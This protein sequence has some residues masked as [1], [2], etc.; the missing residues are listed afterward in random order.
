M[1]RDP[2]VEPRAGDVVKTN[3]VPP[4][5]IEIVSR[6]DKWVS[7]IRASRRRITIRLTTWRKLYADATVHVV[8][9]SDNG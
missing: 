4:L 8:E 7:F 5:N 1:G 6:T 2:R 9:D 3:T